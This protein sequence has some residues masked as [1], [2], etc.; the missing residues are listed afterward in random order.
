MRKWLFGIVA[1]GLSAGPAAAWSEML[2]ARGACYARD[3]GAQHLA[4]HPHQRV[5]RIFLSNTTLAD[6]AHK[7]AVLRFGFALRDGA[8][9][10][11]NAY[12]TATRCSLE[13]DGG[14]FE[15]TR[16]REALRLTVDGFLGLEG[17]AG[18]SGNLYESDDRVFILYPARPAACG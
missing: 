10:E 14:T 1:L 12:C 5:S 18:W 11:A 15:V 3:Y 6:P 9:Y 7:G 17:A 4:S 2:E 16:S 13:G 8:Q